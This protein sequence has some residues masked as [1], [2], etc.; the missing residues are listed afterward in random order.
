ME[1]YLT[2]F[3]H[4]LTDQYIWGYGSGGIYWVSNDQVV[5]EAH[6]MDKKGVLDRGLY[7]VDVV[8]GSYKKVVD[9]PDEGPITYKYCFDGTK[10][11][12]M[13]SRGIFTQTNSPSGYQV[14][15][16]EMGKLNDHN[17]YSPLRCQLVANPGEGAGYGA[18]LSGDGFIKYEWKDK[19]NVHVY[20]T[21]EDGSNVKKLAEQE[22]IRIGNPQGILSLRYMTDERNTYFGYSPWDNKNCT[23][24]WWLHREMWELENQT[25]CL[26]DLSF[27]SL[28]I[29]N[30]QNA[31]YIE[32]YTTHSSYSFILFKDKKTI[33]EKDIGRGA[34]TSPDGCKVAY[35]V[36]NYQREKSLIRQKLKVFDYCE[37]QKKENES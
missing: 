21:M 14:E 7:Q 11:H 12:V 6:I 2:T 37:Y 23:K 25:L 34:A 22:M 26:S 17:N 24:L 3:N 1:D 29:H 9:V 33:I 31:F 8:D 5:L 36:G 20:L 18:L 30:L 19:K 35:G 4:I 16:R 13:R 28:L 15:I 32:H 27:G 10:L